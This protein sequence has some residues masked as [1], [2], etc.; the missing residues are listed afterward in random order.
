MHHQR[1]T[2]MLPFILSLLLLLLHVHAQSETSLYLVDYGF[3]FNLWSKLPASTD[4]SPLIT[5]LTN[6][7]Q[8]IQTKSI[9]GK[10]FSD[11]LQ[12]LKAASTDTL[13]PDSSYSTND[14]PQLITARNTLLTTDQLR[15]AD[16]ANLDHASQFFA[17]KPQL[18]IAKNMDWDKW[19]AYY[20]KCTLIVQN[21]PD[22]IDDVRRF[23]AEWLDNGDDIPPTD[24][25][26]GDSDEAPVSVTTTISGTQTLGTGSTEPPGMSD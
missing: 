23:L 25:F 10:A 21:D 15:Q 5:S 2:S 7:I 14:V 19:N 1:D 9:D 11:L 26:D 13:P 8:T 3:G 24:L 18:V 17:E 4:P 22:R 20:A 12:A 6:I 16:A